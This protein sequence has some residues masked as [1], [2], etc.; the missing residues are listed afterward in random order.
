MTEPARTDSSVIFAFVAVIALLAVGIVALAQALKGPVV[1]TP[2]AQECVCPCCLPGGHIR[3]LPA[4]PPRYP[5]GEF[6][7]AGSLDDPTDY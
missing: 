7:P 6:S 2:A 4:M 1:P 5:K 3:P